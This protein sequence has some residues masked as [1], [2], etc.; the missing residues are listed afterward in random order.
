MQAGK[1]LFYRTQ[2]ADDKYETIPVK[3]NAIYTTDT[4]AKFMVEITDDHATY[5]NYEVMFG[6]VTKDYTT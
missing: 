3:G 4:R 5:P 1:I 6:V 2:S